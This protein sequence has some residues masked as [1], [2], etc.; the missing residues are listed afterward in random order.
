MPIFSTLPGVSAPEGPVPPHL[1][2]VGLPGA[3]KSTVGRL[4]AARVGRPWLDLD[5][6]IAARAGLSVPEI[7][8]RFGEP[9]F[10]DHEVAVTADLAAWGGGLIV[11]AGGGWAANVE[12]VRRVRAVARLAWLR[13]TPEEAI[14]RIRGQGGGR[15]LLE[16]PDPL[17]QLTA[18]AVARQAAYAA[19]DTWLEVSGRT[20][21]E[22]AEALIVTLE[23]DLDR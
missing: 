9:R 16:A 11:S 8:A 18:V 6:E 23:A 5:D 7:F 14:R 4:V 15:P 1:V 20:P 17:A 21:E 3:G 2:L 13:V 19:A 12:A 22:V 10:R